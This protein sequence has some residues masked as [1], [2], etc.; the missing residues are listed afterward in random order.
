MRLCTCYISP[1]TRVSF[2]QIGTNMMSKCSSLSI[3]SDA[4]RM[5]FPFSFNLERLVPYK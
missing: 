1:N 4:C 3:F 5:G 2:E